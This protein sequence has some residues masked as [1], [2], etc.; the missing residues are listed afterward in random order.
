MPFIRSST[1]K[2]CA[3][4]ITS[5]FLNREIISPYFYYAKKGLVYII[6]I[7]FFNRQRFFYLEYTKANIYL[8]YNIRLV[9]LNKYISPYYYIY[10]CVYYNLLIP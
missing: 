8:L 2:R 9:F 6:I 5:I 10:Y 4:L 7:S 3:L 1:F